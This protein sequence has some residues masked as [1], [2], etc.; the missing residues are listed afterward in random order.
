MKQI[1]PHIIQACQVLRK[2]FGILAK[3]SV[4]AETLVKYFGIVNCFHK[5]T[6]KIWIC[7]SD[8]LLRSQRNSRN[9]SK[10][11]AG[12]V[13]IVVVGTSAAVEQV[14]FA[15]S[16][17]RILILESVLQTENRI[18]S[19]WGR[20]KLIGIKNFGRNIK[21]ND[22]RNIWLILTFGGLWTHSLFIWISRQNLKFW[23]FT[24]TFYALTGHFYLRR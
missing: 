15:I 13:L 12:G 10:L 4:P 8:A 9:Y 16:A 18:I 17:L 5:N 20:K 11:G 3:P 21:E 19:S 7:E 22:H 6:E 2:S 14:V 1:W 24:P 23:Y